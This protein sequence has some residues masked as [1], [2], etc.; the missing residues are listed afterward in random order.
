MA[1]V[2]FANI[3]GDEG[4]SAEREY[5]QRHY[6]AEYLRRRAIN[7]QR[8]MQAREA[9]P[10]EQPPEAG[11]PAPGPATPD[12]SAEIRAMASD[13]ATPRSVRKML[14]EELI[15]RPKR[16]YRRKA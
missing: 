16:R 15:E 12:E 4:Y 11:R 1:L 10:G 7:Q 5:L 3:R 6:E 13:P 14:R 8:N 2:D 9:G